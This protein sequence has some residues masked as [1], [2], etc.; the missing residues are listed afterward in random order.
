MT[1]TINY[2]TPEWIAK[3]CETRHCT[4]EDADM[5]W[6]DLEIEKGNPTPFDLDE[7]AEGV[8]KEMRK[9]ARAVNAYGKA[10]KRERKPDAEKR[11]LIARLAE[12][13]ADLSPEVVNP[14]RE[15]RFGSYSITLT[16]HRTPKG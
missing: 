13:L 14:E 2:P 15:I 1:K 5:A 11:E 12:A 8:S 4:P 10:V 9:G 6:W 16:R 7:T 3:W